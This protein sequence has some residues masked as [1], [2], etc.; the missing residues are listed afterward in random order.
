MFFLMI[1]DPIDPVVRSVRPKLSSGKKWQAVG[2]RG[3]CSR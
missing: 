2:E 1:Q 3:V